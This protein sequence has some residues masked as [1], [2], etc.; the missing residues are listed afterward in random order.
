M[1][2]ISLPPSPGAKRKTNTKDDREVGVQELYLE[3]PGFWDVDEAE[4]DSR[5]VL[6]GSEI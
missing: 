2:T 5:V 3:D 6:F 4:K 1:I